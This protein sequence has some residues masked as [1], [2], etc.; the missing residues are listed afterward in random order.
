MES[1]HVFFKELY[2]EVERIAGEHGKSEGKLRLISRLLK[3]AVPHYDWVGFY[4]INPEIPREL[5]LGPYAGEST[6][7]THI[8]FG[9]GVCGQVAELERMIVIQDVSKEENYLSCS[10]SVKSEI[11]LP[12]FA[13]GKFAGELDIDS[14]THAP[15]RDV[16]GEF[17]R[18]VCDLVSDMLP[19]IAHPL[20][21]EAAP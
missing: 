20:S 19:D 1:G 17:L 5:I 15:F 9:R 3:D 14:H 13:K 8:P 18:S 7:H 21:A 6:E 2:Q 10:I 4:I 12:I 16:D 11:V